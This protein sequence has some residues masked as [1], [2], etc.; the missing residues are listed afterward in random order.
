MAEKDMPEEFLRNEYP[1]LVSVNFGV[2]LDAIQ[3]EVP[4][5]VP[6]VPEPEVNDADGAV[7][8][9]MKFSITETATRKSSWD[10]ASSRFRSTM[11]SVVK[12]S[13]NS[14]LRRASWSAAAQDAGDFS[15]FFGGL[16]EGAE[17]TYVTGLSPYRI[18]RTVLTMVSSSIVVAS[19]LQFHWLSAGYGQ[20]P[21]TCK[22]HSGRAS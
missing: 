14:G 9:S 5:V 4:E 7:A 18:A 1:V 17:G 15:Q 3:L 2:G 20:F 11:M 22:R 12:V 8:N 16:I 21:D 19:S 13:V 10:R 6:K